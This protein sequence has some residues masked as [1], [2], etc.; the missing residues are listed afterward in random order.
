LGDDNEGLFRTVVWEATLLE[1]DGYA[2]ALFTDEHGLVKG[3]YG[4]PYYQ[5]DGWDCVHMYR[6]FKKALTE[7]Y[8]TGRSLESEGDNQSMDPCEEL[9]TGDAYFMTSWD[10][11]D[12]AQLLLNVNDDGNAVMFHYQSAKFVELKTAVQ[13]DEEEERF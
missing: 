5:S 1:E 7:E 9:S 13:E 3:G 11:D 4:F 6:K 12:G 10:F 8:G 2:L